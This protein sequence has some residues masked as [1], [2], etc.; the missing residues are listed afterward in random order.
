MVCL[1]SGEPGRPALKAGP[2]QLRAQAV[3]D[4]HSVLREVHLPGTHVHD[5]GDP[6]FQDAPARQLQRDDPAQPRAF[7]SPR[8]G[9][10][11]AGEQF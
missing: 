6:K 8:W 5:V 9:Q 10:Q 4:S 2:V 7:G 11:R 1:P 3:V